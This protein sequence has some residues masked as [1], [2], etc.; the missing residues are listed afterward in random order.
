MRV[1]RGPRKSKD[2]RR[3]W[4]GKARHEPRRR[5]PSSAQ[6]SR[7]DL[8]ARRGVIGVRYPDT[9]S[10]IWPGSP[11]NRGGRC[12][13]GRLSACPRG[14]RQREGSGPACDHGEPREGRTYAGHRRAR[15]ARVRSCTRMRWWPCYGRGPRR[16]RRR[17][18]AVPSPRLRRG[19]LHHGSPLRARGAHR[20]R[21]RLCAPDSHH[22][23]AVL[24]EGQLRGPR[25]RSARG[26]PDIEPHA[27]LVSPSPRYR[28]DA[29][30]GAR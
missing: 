21:R 10:A 29:D 22:L 3:W 30:G 25:I 23:K 28:P 26:P 20:G 4:G 17:R 27:G 8:V 9:E 1:T 6:D 11:A 13:F 19:A 18:A 15:T 14:R 24:P 16:K 7:G 5:G 12:P 2:W